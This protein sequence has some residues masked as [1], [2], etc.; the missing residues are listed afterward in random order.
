MPG[1]GTAKETTKEQPEEGIDIVEEEW[2]RE[3]QAK[4]SVHAKVLRLRQAQRWESR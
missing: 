3:L 2:K 4:G 1:Q